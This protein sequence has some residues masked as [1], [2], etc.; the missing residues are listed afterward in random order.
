MRTAHLPANIRQTLD[1]LGGTKVARTK[2][3][4]VFKMRFCPNRRVITL[5]HRAEWFIQNFGDSLEHCHQTMTLPRRPGTPDS[6]RIICALAKGVFDGDDKPADYDLV[7]SEIREEITRSPDWIRWVRSFYIR[8]KKRAAEAAEFFSETEIELPD[9]WL[10]PITFLLPTCDVRVEIDHPPGLEVRVEFGHPSLRE[11]MPSR[12]GP[13]RLWEGKE[14]FLPFTGFEVSWNLTSEELAKR[15]AS[16][17][18]AVKR[19]EVDIL[20]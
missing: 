14:V 5:N 20:A 6:G 12:R 18:E 9:E 15:E 13:L 8:P 1:E 11:V 4:S 3:T 2:Y 7:E 16:N 19:H 10:E 17:A